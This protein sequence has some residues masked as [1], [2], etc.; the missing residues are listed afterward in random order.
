ME[1][2]FSGEGGGGGRGHSLKLCP[3]GGRDQNV[4]S[5]SFEGSQNQM[6]DFLGNRDNVGCIFAFSSFLFFICCN[7]SPTTSYP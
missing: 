4:I 2:F 5:A 6:S 7:F 1:D 3:V